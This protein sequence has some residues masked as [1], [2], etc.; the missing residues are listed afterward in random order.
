MRQHRI[1]STE[2][3]APLLAACAVVLACNAEPSP[4]TARQALSPAAAG[5]RV[6]LDGSST[7]L[8]VSRIM[9]E[10][11]R[12]KHPDIAV[13]VVGSSTGLGLERLCS[14]RVD[15]AAASRPINAAESDRCK[16]QRIDY[17]EL[18]IAFDSLSV[19]ASK[20]NEFLTCLSV[21][22]LRAVWE[23]AA[24]GR[25]SR[26]SQVR[27]G[28]PDQPI[29]LFGPDNKSGTY[30]YFTLA[31]VGTE[32]SS[33]S[34]Y[35]ASADDEVLERGIAD[36]PNALGFFGYSYY[37]SHR[38]QLRAIAVDNGKGCVAPSPE[39][40]R[41]GSY[42]PL[43]RPL[44]IYV[45]RLAAAR[46]DVRAFTRFFL[47]PE[48]ARLIE[49]VGYVA[50]PASAQ[51]AEQTRFESGVTGSALGAHGSVLGVRPDRFQMDQDRLQSALV[52]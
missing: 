39:S 8:P 22:E 9:L 23:P 52:Q 34:D 10:A 1:L 13:S 4:E 49:S 37:A 16:R 15:I 18:P 30:D 24:E 28:F 36:K 27:A 7:V 33:R 21:A 3:R 31:T 25:I 46:S 45:N 5:G 43:A 51:A 19:V 2:T 41:D 17:I 48:N 14:G 6:E 35:T 44:F 47:S 26:W 29:A 38:D 20:Q 32:G 40:V 12:S 42:Q 50:L 11:F